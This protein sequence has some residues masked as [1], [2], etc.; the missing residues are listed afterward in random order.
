MQPAALQHD[1]ER[2]NVTS[3]RYITLSRADYA[4]CVDRPAETAAVSA[5]PC[6]PAEA[7]ADV[8]ASV[9]DVSVSDRST[10][11]AGT[12]VDQSGAATEEAAAV[13]AAGPTEAPEYN[14]WGVKINL[15]TKRS[16]AKQPGL[17]K[18]KKSKQRQREEEKVDR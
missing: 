4:D 5:R 7:A 3:N 10:V 17:G 12:D 6:L 15:G 11:S 14:R 16:R 18:G 2:D 13:S 8:V 9:G 1:R